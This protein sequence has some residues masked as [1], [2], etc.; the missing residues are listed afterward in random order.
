MY[1]SPLGEARFCVLR[2]NEAQLFVS[3]AEYGRRCEVARFAA[4]VS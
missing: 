2:I 1:S 3:A 4:D